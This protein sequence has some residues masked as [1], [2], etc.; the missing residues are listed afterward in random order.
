[1]PLFLFLSA[2][3]FLSY[4]ELKYLFASHHTRH[5]IS[6]HNQ[7]REFP[8]HIHT[9]TH[10]RHIYLTFAIFLLILFVPSPFSHYFTGADRECVCSRSRRTRGRRGIHQR[11]SRTA[12]QDHQGQRGFSHY[13]YVEQAKA[14][15]EHEVRLPTI[16]MW[17]FITWKAVVYGVAGPVINGLALLIDSCSYWQSSYR[18]KKCRDRQSVPKPLTHKEIGQ[19]SKRS[20]LY[21]LTKH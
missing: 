5:H 1:M 10:I 11:R 3:L 20:K 17:N 7:I 15:P 6:R 14:C 8:P 18:A 12:T 2:I 9:R 4:S 21:H 13:H 19:K 16:A